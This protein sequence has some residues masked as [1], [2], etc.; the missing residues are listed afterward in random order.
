MS[1]ITKTIS[2]VSNINYWLSNYIK[3]ITTYN[4]ASNTNIP[5][6]KKSCPRMSLYTTDFEQ[7]KVSILLFKKVDG[8]SVK[9]IRNYLHSRKIDIL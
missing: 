2:N 6:L 7:V 1:S 4:L 3:H 5:K 9:R 8:R